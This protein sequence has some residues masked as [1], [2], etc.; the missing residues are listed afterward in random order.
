MQTKYLLVIFAFLIFSVNSVEAVPQLI[1][2]Q[3]RLTNPSTGT[4][5]A[6]SLSITFSI[7]DAFTEGTQIWSESQIVELDSNGFFNIL[8]GGI[9][10]LPSLPST[11]F[12]QLQIN[13]EAL[14]PRIQFGSVPFALK[15]GALQ[16]N[17]TT[18][19]I[20]LKCDWFAVDSI[21]SCIPP[22]CPVGFDGLGTANV[23]TAI[24]GSAVVGYTER[25]CGSNQFLSITSLKCPWVFSFNVSSCIPPPCTIGFTDLGTGDVPTATTGGTYVGYSERLCAQ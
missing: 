24:A 20:S 17:A 4:P 14:S 25:L 12:L 9:T 21:G 10:L 16:R 1:S 18:T 6:G 23:P 3:G 15:A 13:G 2:L 8:L 19:T 5:Y 22:S 11:S 7:F